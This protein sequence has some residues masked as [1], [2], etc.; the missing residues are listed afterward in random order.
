MA[1]ARR[2][3]GR[4][5][6]KRSKRGDFMSEP[7]RQ[8]EKIGAAAMPSGEAP[9]RRAARRGLD[10]PSVAINLYL[11][12]TSI[13]LFIVPF[14]L[15]ISVSLTSDDDILAYGYRLI[16]KRLD[17]TAFRFAFSNMSQIVDAYAVTALQSFAGTLF[18]AAV[19][20]F[21]AYSLSRRYF[22][23][24]KQVTLYVFFTMIFSG[25]LIP[26]YIINTQ[27]LHIG[28]S[29][30]IYLLPGLV[31]PFYVIVMRTFLKDIPAA[32]PESAKIDGA[33][34][35]IILLRIIL[36]L[37]KPVLATVSLLMLL[38]KWNNWY[39]AMIYIRNPKLYTLQYL[40]Q[41]ILLESQAIQGMIDNVP[42]GMTRQF[43]F[44]MPIESL[45][46]AMCLI[47]AGPMLLVFPFFQKHFSKGLTIGA[48]KG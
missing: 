41:K 22:A 6:Q 35:L 40:L 4:A 15:V 39:T 25:G 18:G 3:A 47:A 31:S 45:R 29:I 1:R 11:C 24:R 34:E 42:P 10:A 8:T 14:L 43:N 27:F 19:M 13:V 36:P 33:S 21:C 26:S 28:N 46:Y 9:P 17:F 12:A 7:Q 20:F 5:A 37:S 23:F 2:T 48:V 16:P 38:D 44:R 32:L 30:W